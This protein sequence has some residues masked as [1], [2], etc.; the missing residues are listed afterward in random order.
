MKIARGCIRCH[1]K[2]LESVL[3]SDGSAQFFGSAVS[4]CRLIDAWIELISVRRIL[5][6]DFFFLVFYYNIYI[7]IWMW[8]NWYIKYTTIVLIVNFTWFLLY[9]NITYQY[10]N[11]CERYISEHVTAFSLFFFNYIGTL[12][13]TNTINSSLDN[14]Y[15]SLMKKPGNS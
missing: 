11:D 7:N 14:T 13:Y 5:F 6:L 4:I 8:M 12:D 3:L 1:R 10:M 2:K 15:N 9:F